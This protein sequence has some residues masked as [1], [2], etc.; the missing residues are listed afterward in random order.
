[1][2]NIVIDKPTYIDS[3]PSQLRDFVRYGSFEDLLLNKY[4]N[5]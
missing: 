5:S 1:M 4:N 2:R 3:V